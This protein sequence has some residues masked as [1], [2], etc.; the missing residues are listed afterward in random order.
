MSF[1]LNLKHLETKMLVNRDFKMPD[2][3]SVQSYKLL[4][5]VFLH[6]LSEPFWLFGKLDLFP[7][8]SELMVCINEPKLP[9]GP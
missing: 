9:T 8:I 2:S 5:N 1:K 3:A 7:S 4:E 6:L